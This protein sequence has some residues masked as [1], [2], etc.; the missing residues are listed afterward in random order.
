MGSKIRHFEDDGWAVW[1]DGDEKSTVYF[2]EW[3]NPSGKNYVDVGI[4]IYGAQN[5]SEVNVYIPFDVT[6]DEIEDLSPKLT[7]ETILRGIFNNRCRVNDFGEKGLFEVTYGRHVLNIIR[8]TEISFNVSKLSVGVKLTINL[9]EIQ[10]KITGKEL[11][12][13]F[14]VP[15][16]SMDRIFEKK[17]EMQSSVSKIHEAITSPMVT[18]KYG[19][20]IRINEARLLP[21]EISNIE[22]LH[23]QNL[24][25]ALVSIS[26]DE[27]Y[28][29]NDFSCYKIRHLESRLYDGYAPH[30]FDCNLSINYQWK[31]ERE[32]DMKAHFNFYFDIS[33]STVSKK[34]LTLYFIIV[35]A[36]SLVGNTLYGLLLKLSS[37]IFG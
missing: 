20:A 30:G 15:H 27:N 18:E 6:L 5:A 2:N 1:N 16:K 23:Q 10:Q 31:E 11:Y 37:V 25:K 14:R 7:D 21:P 17:K 4:R 12:V 28:E 29:L 8:F 26:I 3:I 35:L 13:I 24:R 19:Y 36:S 9:L 33:R 32:A 34:S 22:T